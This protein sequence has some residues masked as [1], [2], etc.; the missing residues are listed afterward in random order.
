MNIIFIIFAQI[1]YSE[2]PK[3]VLFSMNFFYLFTLLF[4]LLHIFYI[5]QLFIGKLTIAISCCFQCNIIITN[6]L[7]YNRWIDECSSLELI[8]SIVYICLR[9]YICVELQKMKNNSSELNG[10]GLSNWYF[11]WVKHSIYS[12]LL[13]FFFLKKINK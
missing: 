11:M 7:H 12:F 4:H 10:R 8:C 13:C 6:T 1:S 2:F 5:P 3:K 9:S